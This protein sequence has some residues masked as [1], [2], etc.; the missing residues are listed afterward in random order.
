MLLSFP[1]EIDLF[2]FSFKPKLNTKSVWLEIVYY[3]VYLNI[4]KLKI[5]DS[6]LTT[7]I[8]LHQIDL[9]CIVIY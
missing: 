2:E 5:L 8:F 1:Q 3:W 7:S 6:K 9:N 4:I